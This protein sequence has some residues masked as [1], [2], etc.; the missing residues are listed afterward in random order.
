MNQYLVVKDE[1]CWLAEAETVDDACLEAARTCSVYDNVVGITF[2]VYPY[3]FSMRRRVQYSDPLAPGDMGARMPDYGRP[4]IVE[5][6]VP[7][8]K[9]GVFG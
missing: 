7:I 8:P 9:A 2:D 5:E 4:R 3:G 1:R 6:F